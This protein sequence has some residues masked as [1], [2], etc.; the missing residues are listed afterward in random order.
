[1][2]L[3]ELSKLAS[4]T[5]TNNTTTTTTENVAETTSIDI[6]E[7]ISTLK[8]D[9]DNKISI[10]M[11]CL[12]AFNEYFRSNYYFSVHDS[13]YLKKEMINKIERGFKEWLYRH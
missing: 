2:D 6:E 11:S 4:Q 1:M 10:L 8:S 3:T 5:N 7:K 9:F 12:E 13:E